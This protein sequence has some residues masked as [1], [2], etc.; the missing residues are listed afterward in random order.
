MFNHIVLLIRQLQQR[1]PFYPVNAYNK[2]MWKKG[3][4]D[5]R[6]AERAVLLNGDMGMV[7]LVCVT[8]F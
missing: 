8:I 7:M 3:S 4:A 2:T 1:W 5:A 6:Q